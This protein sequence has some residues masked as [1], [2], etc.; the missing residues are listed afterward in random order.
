MGATLF[1][2]HPGSRIK[3]GDRKFD[4]KTPLL[5]N[6]LNLNNTGKGAHYNNITAVINVS[7][8]ILCRKFLLCLTYTIIKFVYEHK[9][10]QVRA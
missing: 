3:F 5:I 7:C 6:Y 10:I 2:G 1:S 8:K 4:W 9:K